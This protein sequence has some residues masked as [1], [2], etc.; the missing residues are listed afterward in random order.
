MKRLKEQKAQEEL[1]F[2]DAPAE[3]YD[4]LM[5]TLMTDPVMLP[6]SRS[7]V[8]RSTII[9]HLLNSETDPFNRQPLSEN[10]LMPSRCLF[11]LCVC[12]FPHLLF[13][14]AQLFAFSLLRVPYYTQS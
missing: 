6:G 13:I 10:D 5:S 7:V 12:R 3:F 9:M 11:F 2:G 4:T 1:D 8:D 14:F